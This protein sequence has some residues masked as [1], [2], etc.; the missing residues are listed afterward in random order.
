MA[1]LR[2]QMVKVMPREYKRALAEQA[3]RLEREAEAEITTT[4][5]LTG[6]A[7]RVATEQAGTPVHG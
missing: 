2:R 5:A 6:I 7:A 3:A 1:M 4:I